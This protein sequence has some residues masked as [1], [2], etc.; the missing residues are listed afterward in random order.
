MRNSRLTLLIAL[1]AMPALFAQIKIGDNPQA[2]S[3]TSVLELESNDR[4][5]VI[6]RINTTQMNAIVPN[7]GAMVYNTDTQCIHYFDG[8]QWVNLCNSAGFE[9]AENSVSSIHVIDFSITGDDIQ[10]GS[11]GPGK[12]QNESV[13]Q[14][15]LGENSVG[16][17]A[18]DNAN[19]GVTAFDNDAGY[20]TAADLDIVS[21]A[22]GN[23][24]TDNG[25]AYYDDSF[26]IADIAQNAADIALDNDTN[27]NNEIQSLTLT[28]NQLEISGSNT[29]TLPSSA[30]PDGSETI[31]TQG[32]NVTITG[33]GTTATPYVINATGGTGSTEI[34][35]QTTI[36]GIGTAADPF[37]IEPGGINQVL[38]TNASGVIEWQA[39]GTGG[40]TEIADQ[41]TIT[42]IGTAAD[43]F[44]IEPG[45]D[46]Q[47]LTTDASGDVIWQTVAPG[48]GEVNT[49]SNSGTGGIGI[50]LNKNG[51]DLPFKSLNTGDSGLLTISDDT[52]N[53]EIDIDITP[54]APLSPA[55]DQM[56]ITNSLTDAVEWAEV[57]TGLDHNGTENSIF[58]SDVNGDPTFADGEFFWDTDVREENGGNFGALGIGLDGG[59]MST[60]S[61]VHVAEQ[62]NGK[63]S[64]PLEIQNRTNQNTNNSSV[65]L[66]FSVD[67]SNAHGKGALAY[68]RTGDWGVGDFHF[69]Q[70]LDPSSTN[71]IL[72]D[73]ILSIES[74][75]DLVLTGDILAKNGAATSVGWVLTNTTNGTEWAPS[76]GSIVQDT[77]TDD[78][79]THQ[80]AASGYDINV[81]GST[82]EIDTD[83]LRVKP[84]G[85]TSNEIDDDAVG[86]DQI[87]DFSVSL[88]KIEPLA[89]APAT[90]Q[91]LITNTAGSVVWQAVPT[92]TGNLATTNLTQT[93]TEDRTYNMSGQTLTFLNGKIGVGTGT[94]DTDPNVA[95]HVLGNGQVRAA[96]FKVANGSANLPAYRF[97]DDLN[98]GM[99]LAN[100][101][102]SELG[103]S[104]A[105]T[106]AIRID[107]AQNVGIGTTT[108]DESLHVGNNMRL[109]GAFEDKDGEAGNADYILSSTGTATDWI[110]APDGVDLIGSDTSVISSRTLVYP[111][112]LPNANYI[113]NV[114]VQNND[115]SNPMIA[116]ITGKTPTD[117]SIEIIE[118][119]GTNFVNSFSSATVYYTIYNQ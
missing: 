38:T 105:S 59:V 107:D 94:I 88:A 95:L 50:V 79:L 45:T 67:L 111:T 6:T 116:T 35:D 34:A 96:S 115:N 98:T 100:P 33:D 13:T 8:T 3:P 112:A 118:W 91:M 61:K 110:V 83:A 64:Y 106:E 76:S 32:T 119:N 56:L 31:V 47:F 20:I 114:S 36:T 44:T 108:P 7:Q 65:G 102:G 23:V 63:L 10:N 113:V 87:E 85:I 21:A 75:G 97:T 60:K 22:A 72:D 69:L 71:P 99:F 16:A 101:S 78:G 89:P 28:G 70:N 17:Y 62:L 55:A 117:L 24:I 57:P 42:G 103:F 109:D 93:A 73:K 90:N 43:P 66:L 84:N 14:D 30:A 49:A 58:F 2:I 77:E 11:I 12:L 92:G 53:N 48:V 18:L 82:I 52:A 46:G 86:E 39:G 37:T 27:A 40:T 41:T 104:T 81:D 74:D 51:L 1:F 19:I 5:L 4:V 29:V 25:G 26:L 15:K 80:L 54:A 68:E 9:L